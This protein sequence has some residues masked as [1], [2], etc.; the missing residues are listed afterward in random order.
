M[1]F[2]ESLIKARSGIVF[3]LALLAGTALIFWLE[4][5]NFSQGSGFYEVNPFPGTE[6]V[7]L[8]QPRKL[9]PRELAWAETAWQYFEK[10]FQP[11]TGLVNSVEQFPATTMWDT[12]SYLMA[13]ISAE[14]LDII[15]ES[16]FDARMA[17]CLKTLATMPLFQDALP[18][19]SYNTISAAMVDYENKEAPQ[20]I[21]WSA[22]DICRIMV[23]FQVLVWHY[24]QHTP[25]VGEVLQRWQLG[26]MVKDGV[27]WGAVRE[28]GEVE[29]VQEGRLGYE[30][31]AAKSLNLA[32]MNVREALEVRDFLG[33]V[34]TFGIT[35][36]HDTRAPEI[37]EAR[38]YVV[39]EP[40]ILSGIE[41]GWDTWDAYL[42]SSV[43]RAQ[44][45]RFES[46]GILTAVSEDHV[47]QAPYFV[48][49]TVFS[50]GK[51]WACITEQGKLVDE[52]R[53]LSTKAAIGWYALLGNDYTRKLVDE[54]SL[55]AKPEHGFYAGKY[56]ADG[57]PNE[58]LSANTNAIILESLAY[59]E[60]GPFLQI[61]GGGGHE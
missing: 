51:L 44:E 13:L 11:G 9:D 31:Y 49:N 54:V 41:F 27:L 22:I 7:A 18:N 14:R 26:A 28:G 35:I 47:D 48:Y 34:K 1:S 37:F 39:S 17:L 59:I 61:A 36:A 20:G 57:R 33:F 12:A 43:Y 56:E 21:G 29:M 46:L 52:L 32:G 42:G 58:S 23:P 16:L 60:G 38:T 10:N 8:A 25:A 5:L 19:K 55:L 45:A 30:E 6:T 50:D 40:Y 15:G 3:V 4:N 53:T 24:P 2:G